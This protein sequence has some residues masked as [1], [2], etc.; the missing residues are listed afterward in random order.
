VAWIYL[1]GW[2]MRD[3]TVHFRNDIYKHDALPAKQFMVSLERPPALTRSFMLQSAEPEKFA[4][5]SYL[6]SR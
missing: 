3:G 1:T 4:P 5:V 2:A 6:D